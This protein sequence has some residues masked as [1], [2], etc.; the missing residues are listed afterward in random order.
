[1]IILGVFVC[2][3]GM[4]WIAD[5]VLQTHWQAS[6]KSSN[7]EALTRHVAVYAASISVMSVMVFGLGYGILFVAVNA[8]LHWCTDYGT[9]RWSARLFGRDWHD[10]FVVLG[11]DQ[12]IHQFTIAGTLAGFWY[13]TGMRMW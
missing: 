13:L 5:Y 11:L 8:V 7:N 4:H 1:M 9:S 3:L 12:L 6:N 10:F 2:F